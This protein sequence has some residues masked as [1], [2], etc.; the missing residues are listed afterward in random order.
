MDEK[1]K[2]FN[3]S[4]P[5]SATTSVGQMVRETGFQV[6]DGHWN[7]YKSNFLDLAAVNKDYALI[8]KVVSN[9]NYFSDLPFGG[10]DYFFEARKAFPNSKFFFIYRDD[11]SWLR[12]LLSMIDNNILKGEYS[13]RS[14]C[15]KVELCFNRGRYGFSLWITHF[16]ENDLTEEGIIKSKQKYE[17]LIQDEFSNAP[18]FEWYDLLTLDQDNLKSFLGIDRSAQLAHSNRGLY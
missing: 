16:C 8:N 5:K 9:F 6:C 15:E 18:N 7:D 17:N 11:R 3:L 12:S 4:L 2:Y 14:I 10:S 13:N 1:L